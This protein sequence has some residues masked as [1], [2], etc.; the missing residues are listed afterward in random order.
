MSREFVVVPYDW[1]KSMELQR[2]KRETTQNMVITAKEAKRS[3]EAAKK[4]SQGTPAQ[5]LPVQTTQSQ[6]ST[7]PQKQPIGAELIVTQSPYKAFDP[8]D[9]GSESETATNVSH[10]S[11]VYETPKYKPR[12]QKDIVWQKFVD[13][14]LIGNEIRNPWSKGATMPVNVNALREFIFDTTGKTKEPEEAIFALEYFRQPDLQRE[15]FKTSLN[16]RFELLM[17]ARKKTPNRPERQHADKSK[18]GSWII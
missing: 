14:A 7:K 15:A 8:E 13:Q 2:I 1:Y 3:A 17:S 4:A 10:L 16:P 18:T 6:T 12:A 9:S 5:A 11:D